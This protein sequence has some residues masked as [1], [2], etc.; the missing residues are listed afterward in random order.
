MYVYQSS[1][2]PAKG[3]LK[4]GFFSPGGMFHLDSYSSDAEAAAARVNYLN[5]G[6]GLT[7]DQV[8]ELIEIM[9]GSA[10]TLDA[11]EI[12]GETQIAVSDLK[13]KLKKEK[14]PKGEQDQKPE[15]DKNPKPKKEPKR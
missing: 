12:A 13:A 8:S 5:G 7:Q 9:L 15:D 4:I 3:K 11:G 14:P 6:Y 2:D 10:V 1:D